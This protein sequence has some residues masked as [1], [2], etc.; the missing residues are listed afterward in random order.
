[1]PAAGIVIVGTGLAGYGVARELRK[2]DATVPLTLVT[3]DEGA[4]YS[5]PQL[6]AAWGSGK[7]PEQLVLKDAASMSTDLSA[8]VLTGNRVT[9]ADRDGNRIVLEDGREIGFRKLVLAVGAR[10]RIPAI[11]LRDGARIHSVNNLAHYARLRESLPGQGR[12]AILGAGLIGCEFA[13]DFA[14]AGFQVTLIGRGAGLLEGLVPDSVSSALQD[15]LGKLGVRFLANQGIEDLSASGTGWRARLQGGQSVD[16]DAFLSAIGFLPNLDLA[17][18]LGLETGRGIKVDLS[19]RS[20]R[21]EIFALGDCAEIAGRWLPFV[22][23]INHSAKALGQ[24]LA[25]KEAQ[26]TFPL[27]PVLI[28][29]PSFP[30]AVL[31]PPRESQGTWT[32]TSDSG[33]VSARF[34]DAEGRVLGFAVGRNRYPERTALLREMAGQSPVS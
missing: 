22:L 27:M 9:G 1:M 4:Y 2:W 21:P 3:E 26:V 32:E 17:T 25:G 29:T 18:L 13:H 10:A 16:A 28:K 14:Q 33:G 31:P 8:E 11:T 30:L 24:V 12:L 20:S 19:L 7:T 23:P 34:R 15:A 6:S 5:K